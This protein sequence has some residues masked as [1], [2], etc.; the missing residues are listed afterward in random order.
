MRPALLE[1]YA[2]AGNEVSDRTGHQDLSGPSQSRNSGAD[3]DGNAA[4]LVADDFALASVETRAYTNSERFDAGR[5]GLGA[6]YGTCWAV[7]GGEEAIAGRVNFPAAEAGELA[8]RKGVVLAEQ[9]APLPIP[10]RGGSF[11]RTHDVG[12]EHRGQDSIDLDLVTAPREKL[13]DLVRDGI[14]VADPGCVVS[15]GK[16][17]EARAADVRGK[18]AALFDMDDAIALPVEDE[19]RHMDGG[20]TGRTS[21]SLFISMTA[22]AAPGLAAS[23]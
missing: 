3:V 18:V 1:T 5:Y 6:A 22:T 15:A 9:L 13:L 11:R 23:R 19:R 7:E 20:R 4:H 2:G 16:L 14:H 17:D 21:I 12:E 10:E 8:S